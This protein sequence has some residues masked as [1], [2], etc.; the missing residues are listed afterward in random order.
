MY[1]ELKECA[2]PN[3][4]NPGDTVGA[5]TYVRGLE[6][7][8]TGDIEAVHVRTIGNVDHLVYREN[9]S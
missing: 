2:Y 4:T 8:V 6:E 1:E 3:K 7:H 5:I 9:F